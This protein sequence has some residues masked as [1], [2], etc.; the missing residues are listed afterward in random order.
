M[1]ATPAPGRL[2]AV[3]WGARRIGLA[4]S[5]ETRTIAQ[6]LGA[7]TRRAGKRFPF[8]DLLDRCHANRVTG[9]VV[10]LPLTPDG[11][12]GEAATAARAL[13]DDL[14]AKSGLPVALW[15]ERLTTAR[16]LRAV[17]ELDGS[18]RG[19]KG[20]VDALAATVLLQH[21]LDAHRGT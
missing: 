4:L 14:A 1:S 21:Y 7:L 10:G 16:A 8:R 18:T 20:D 5:D 3:D 9:L 19:R 17:R 2:L 12:E 15:D 6:P 11:T 13:A